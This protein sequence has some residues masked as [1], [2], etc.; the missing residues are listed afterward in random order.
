VRRREC[1]AV[2]GGA[3]LAWPLITRAQQPAKFAR[4][5]VLS[6]QSPALTS[7][8]VAPFEKGLRELGYVEAQNIAFERRDAH[9]SQAAL[10]HMAAELIHAKS[11]A[12][13]AIGT[14]AARAAKEASST[15]P[16]VFVRVGDPVASGLV[17]SIA[18]PGG[19]LTGL[20]LLTVDL[21][22]KRLEL[23]IQS[24][25]GIKKVGVLSEAA[26]ATTAAQLSEVERASRLLGIDLKVVPV[27]AASEFD[28]A[29]SA[30]MAER[31]GALLVTASI[32]LTENRTQLS[33]LALTARLPAIAVRREFPEAGLFMSYGSSFSAMFRRAAAYMDKILK[34]AKPADFPVEQPDRI[35]MVINVRTARALGIALS[36]EVL[37]RADEVIE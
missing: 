1:I 24:V 35:E 20:S 22:A 18:S 32:L 8:D 16:V 26:F 11:D 9:G 6:D 30:M 23:L 17:R 34:G 29:I 36:P 5:G 27:R 4:I 3:S 15:A 21:S 14:A 10:S 31:V 12:I 28:A 13:L 25:Q 2:L 7:L 19:N 37:A 33:Q